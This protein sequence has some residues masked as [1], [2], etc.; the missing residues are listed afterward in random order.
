MHLK[1]FIGI[2]WAVG[3]TRKVQFL[4]LSLT[5]TVLS[6]L[7][8]VVM[9]ETYA[10]SI[11]IKK[12]KSNHKFNGAPPINALRAVRR[13]LTGPAASVPRVCVVGP[14]ERSEN[15]FQALNLIQILKSTF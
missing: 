12:F 13:P 10:K 5:R 14:N 15:S 8:S 6:I 2:A 3:H 7:Y 9:L 1:S 4:P 11:L